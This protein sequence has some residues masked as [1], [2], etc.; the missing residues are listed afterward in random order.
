SQQFRKIAIAHFV[1]RHRSELW[2]QRTVLA[3]SLVIGKDKQ[4]I[5]EDGHADSAAKLVSLERR[6]CYR[7][8][9]WIEIGIIGVQFAVSDKPESTAVDL[10]GAGLQRCLNNATSRPAKFRRGD[11]G[12]DTKFLNGFCRREEVDAVYQRFVVID[13]VEDK[14]ISLG[15]QAV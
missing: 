3:Q 9:D 11:G 14:V 13:A 15:A 2:V 12:V 1:C 10:I 7:L 8:A 4:L 6:L 5:L